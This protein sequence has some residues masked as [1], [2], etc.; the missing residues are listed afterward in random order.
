M[1]EVGAFVT[2]QGL[3]G[4]AHLNGLH[5]VVQSSDA[6]RVEVR[7]DNGDV[8]RLKR[9]NLSVRASGGGFIDQ[10][11]AKV[12]AMMPSQAM[13]ALSKVQAIM[14][15]PFGLSQRQVLGLLAALVVVFL[16]TTLGGMGGGR[17]GGLPRGAGAAPPPPRRAAPRS[18]STASSRQRRTTTQPFVELAKFEA[19]AMTQLLTDT[20]KAGYNDA[21]K[22][23]DYGTSDPYSTNADARLFARAVNT[24]L[25]R[26]QADSA[27][28]ETLREDK[29]SNGFDDDDDDE[30]D[31]EPFMQG[32][33]PAPRR[34]GGGGMLGMIGPLFLGKQLF[35][36]G[37][38]PG[39]ALG[40]PGFWVPGLFVSGFKM[41]PA[42]RKGIMAMMALRMFGLSPI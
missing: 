2:A 34:S 22:S 23:L 38:A 3:V 9:S 25:E 33:A 16:A 14:P 37:R 42:W 6:A 31:D 15:T 12:Q 32:A 4:A 21:T 19:D 10:A 13:A 24:A 30:E 11:M 39:V 27:A 35:D 17:G 5:G 7:F 29:E 8:K 28:E 18:T 40:Q 41:L 26:A 36:L 1:Y 20:Y